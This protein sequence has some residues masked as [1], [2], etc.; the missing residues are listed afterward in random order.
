[1][2]KSWHDIKQFYEDLIRGG[3]PAQVMLQLEEHISISR[4]ASGLFA[5][6]SMHDL[7][8]AKTPATEQDPGPYLRISPLFDG[9]IDFRF[10]DTFVENRQWHR[11]VSEEE[12]FSRLERFFDQLHWFGLKA[13]PGSR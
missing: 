5:W 9:N 7:C 1:V 12:A 3:L 8:V 4:Y 6:T 10:I 2:G 13:V 11:V